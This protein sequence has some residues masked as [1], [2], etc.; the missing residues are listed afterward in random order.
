MNLHMSN[1]F[2]EP[3]GKGRTGSISGSIT[4]DNGMSHPLS[5][6]SKAPGSE[7]KMDLEEQVTRNT[8]TK[9]IQII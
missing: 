8:K 4:S 3:I 9:L 2:P 7:R 5:F 6:S 1:S